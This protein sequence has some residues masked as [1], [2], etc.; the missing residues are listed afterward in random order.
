MIS[1]LQ[2]GEIEMFESAIGNCSWIMANEDGR[3]QSI[4][5]Y[6]PLPDPIDDEE[7]LPF[8]SKI[9]GKNIETRF[10]ETLVDTSKHPHPQ[11]IISNLCGYNYSPENYRIQARR[12]KDFGFEQMRSQR[13]S[14]GRFTEHWFL[15][16]SGAAEGNLKLF[17]DK[18]GND[19]KAQQRLDAIIDFL[20]KNVSF[21]SLE[22]AY[23]RAAMVIND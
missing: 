13:D 8:W 1:G 23:Q 12:L 5:K 18:L 14:A 2:G 15:E 11:I 3:I 16:Y 7:M 6:K 4:P 21:G 22:I 9:E 19:I 20:C 10:E 17:I